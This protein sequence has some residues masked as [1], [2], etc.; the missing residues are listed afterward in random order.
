MNWKFLAAPPPPPSPPRP[1]VT[2]ECSSEG[3]Y[4]TVSWPRGVDGDVKPRLAADLAKMLFLLS[5]GQL[6]ENL[7]GGI[8][9]AGMYLGEPDIAAMTNN[10]FS[11]ALNVQEL[12]AERPMVS[13]LEALGFTTSRKGEAG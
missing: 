11:H 1:T 12:M 13:P 8:T 3:I 7:Q 4:C 2:L 6:I 10:F 5:S 9:K